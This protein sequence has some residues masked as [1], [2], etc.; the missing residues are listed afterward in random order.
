MTQENIDVRSWK[1]PGETV[2]S[3]IVMSSIPSPAAIHTV[4]SSIVSVA[5]QRS[6]GIIF[7][8]LCSEGGSLGWD[9]LAVKKAEIPRFSHSAFHSDG[10]GKR[11]RMWRRAASPPTVRILCCREGKGRALLSRGRISRTDGQKR[12]AFTYDGTFKP[13]HT[14]Q[15]PNTRK[16][17]IGRRECFVYQQAY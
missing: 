7:L 2:F 1:I 10:A 8:P 9:Q 12:A 16:P 3:R 11:Q 17:F 4:A 6:Q 13:A 5:A 14:S 15:R